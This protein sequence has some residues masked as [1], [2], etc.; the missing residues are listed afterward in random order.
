MPIEYR[1]GN[2]DILTYSDNAA[3]WVF[4]RLAHF[5]YLFYNRVIGDIQA[6]QNEL[7]NGYQ[8]MVATTDSIA[9]SA[10]IDD[11]QQAVA[12]L[13]EF[14]NWAGH[15]TVEQWRDFGNY[16]L[17]RYLD[18]NI[19]QV[20]ENGEF[21]RNGY[22]YPVRPMQPGYPDSWKRSVIEAT[23]DRFER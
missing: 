21:L 22:G 5:K 20:D 10:F 8:A 3:F 4:N 17:V 15:N 18:S 11:P 13:T 9:M 2:G 23:G 1:V 19:K 7:E 16:L 12:Q 14:S 6:K